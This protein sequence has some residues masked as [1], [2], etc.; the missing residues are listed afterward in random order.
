M[1]DLKENRYLVKSN[2]YIID[3]AQVDFI[4]WKEN[5]KREAT[6]WAKLHIGSKEARYVCNNITE[7]KE[8]ISVW[9]ELKDKRIIV[10]EEELLEE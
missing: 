6:Y 1:D 8:L 3:L 9:T 2:S 5:E 10:S 7:L 4:T